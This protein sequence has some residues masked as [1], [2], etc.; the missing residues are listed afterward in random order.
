MCLPIT[1][2]WRLAET[3]STARLLISI[4]LPVHIYFNFILLIFFREDFEK[5]NGMS[6]RYWGWGLEDD[7]FYTR[8]KDAQI[9]I[10]RPTSFPTNTT[11]TF[12]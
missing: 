8:L 5:V 3:S 7:E 1:W 2:C 4:Y 9:E 10:R 11:N 6:N 12:L